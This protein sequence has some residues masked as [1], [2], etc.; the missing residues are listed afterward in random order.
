MISKI[1]KKQK[2]V[3]IN[4]ISTRKRQNK[5]NT[6]LILGLFSNLKTVHSE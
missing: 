2:I 5:K 6:V 3:F 1:S 4:G